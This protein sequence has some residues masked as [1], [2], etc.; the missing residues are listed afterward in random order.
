MPPAAPTAAPPPRIAWAVSAMDLPDRGSVL[1]IGCG[2][3]LAVEL[4]CEAAPQLQ[5]FAID[6]SEAMVTAARQRNA[7]HI[8]AGRAQIHLGQL[9]TVLGASER[10]DVVFAV[11]VS[12]F[13]TKPMVP[14][15]RALRRLVRPGGAFHLFYDAPT[16]AKV[17]EITSSLLLALPAAGVVDPIAHRPEDGSPNLAGISALV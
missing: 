10:Y 7:S 4:I 1:E 8:H 5:V 16:A 15:L 2:R 9:D 17:A 13:W 14:P 11:N 6:R 3:G 12:V